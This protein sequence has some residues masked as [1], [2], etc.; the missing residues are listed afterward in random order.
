[1]KLDTARLRGKRVLVV[2]DERLIALDNQDLLESW[3]C[4]V[5]GPA[6]SVAEALLLLEPDLPDAAVLDFDLGGETSEPV[7]EALCRAN[8]P[9]VVTTGYATHH[10]GPCTAGA[11]MLDKPVNADAL[12]SAL[13]EL[14]GS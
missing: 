1:M 9:F 14:L 13:T 6:G 7:A 5:V 3:G 12:K 2:E 11:R 10:L 4:T 8:R